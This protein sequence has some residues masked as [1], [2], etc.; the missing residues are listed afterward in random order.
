MAKLYFR[1]G[2][3]NSGKSTLLI[4]TAYNYEERGMKILLVKP[5]IDTKGNNLIVSRIGKTRE[6]NEV[7][8]KDDNL[9]ELVKD[10]Y[11]DVSCVL[12]DEAQFLEPKQ[13]DECMKVVIDLDI[14]VICYGLRTDFKMNGFPGATSL[15]EIASS[16]EEMKTICECGDGATRNVRFVNHLPTFSGEQV[17]ILGENEVTYESMCR[18]CRKKLLKKINRGEK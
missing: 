8:S 7:L 14:P 10:K 2:A 12:I 18:N 4:Q 13:V 16:I 1:Y 15:L 5:K 3:M 6:V 17:A 9:Y 11:S